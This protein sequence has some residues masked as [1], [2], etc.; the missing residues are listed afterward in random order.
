MG[1]FKEIQGDLIKLAQNGEF[2][3]I[4]HGCNCHCVMGAGIAPQ[5]AKA[6]DVDTLPKEN[7]RWKGDI[8]KLGN[9]DFRAVRLIH[10]SKDK[11]RFLG[12]ANQLFVESFEKN[13]K[14]LYTVNAYTQYNYGANHPDGDARPLDYDA[15][16]L[17]FKKINHIFK[18]K[19][20][21]LPLIGCGLAGGNWDIVKKLMQGYLYD[22]DV[23]VVHYKP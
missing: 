8:R 18:G 17:C 7:I 5:M 23:T 12:T 13:E 20:I 4:A 11:D 3:V 15:L 6:F 9:I 1:S 14:V 16:K 21:G 10:D 2:E 22:M 19:H